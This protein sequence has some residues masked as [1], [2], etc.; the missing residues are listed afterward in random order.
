MQGV[1]P[2]VLVDDSAY[3]LYPTTG[4]DPS[5]FY[6]YKSLDLRHWSKTAPALKAQDISWINKDKAPS[7]ALWAPG[8]FKE[9]R[10]YYLFFAV[11]PQNPTPSRIG[12]ATS[13]SPSGPFVDSGS[14]LIPGSLD[15]EAIDP[16]GFKDSVRG[17]VYLYCGGSA[18]PKMHAYELTRDRL[19]VAKQLHVATPKDF[20]EGSF[21]HKQGE[22]YYPRVMGDGTM[23][24]IRWLTRRLALRSDLGRIEAPYCKPMLN[25]QDQSTM[26]F[27]KTQGLVSGL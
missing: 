13:A 17:R 7:H 1:D 2:D 3:W 14:P 26:P 4:D 5:R 27:F 18:G 15:F 12:V 22:L 16:M 6:A 19:H 11:G 24:H 23:I 20:T 8:I 21:M 25:M 10:K 9:G